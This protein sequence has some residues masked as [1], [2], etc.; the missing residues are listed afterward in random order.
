MSALE[1]DIVIIGSG[2]AGGVLAATLAEHTGQ[3]IVL[4]E[5]GG[6]FTHEFFD[7]RELDMTVLLADR[8]ARATVDGAIPVTG[9]ECVGGGTTVNYALS[10]DPIRDV[11]NGWKHEFGVG[12]FSFDR[13]SNDFGITGLNMATCLADLRRRINVHAPSDA[14][15]N[16][17]NKLF[18]AG[19][20]ASGI[21]T[22]RFEL[23]MIDCIGCGFCGQGCAYDR[24]LSTM[25]TYVRDAQRRNVQLVHHCDVQRIGFAARG[26]DRFATGVQA[27]VRPTTPG[28][29]ANS[30]DRGPLDIRAK[31][32]IVS[33]GAI[34]SPA[35]LQR[36]QI[37]DP[38]QLMGKGLV[39]HPSLPIGGTF[40]RQL[41][42]YRGI[43]GSI[44]SDHFY[45]SHGFYYESL[46]D[47]PMNA[48]IAIP[49]IGADH[50]AIMSQYSKLAGFGVMLVDTPNSANRVDWDAS[51]GRPAIRYRLTQPD[52]AR[53]RYAARVGIEI[54]LAAGA[55]EALLTS[56]EQPGTM[57][58]T[59]FKKRQDAAQCEKLEFLPYQTLIT[60]AHCQAT[61]KMGEDPKRSVVNSRGETHGVR[62]LVVCDSSVFPTSC[63]A[64]P[65][66]SVM[67][68]ARYQA[69]RIAN[70]LSRYGLS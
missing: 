57:A 36:S 33:A 56:E 66:I 59:I 42:N 51:S 46:F 8:G 60:S 13:G 47:H 50:F 6:H 44:Y 18:A 49:G 27:V 52:K 35:L 10:F 37:P 20:K 23:N 32:V 64:N 9:G 7:Q 61:L 21:P 55:N 14:E 16:D 30:V 63:G 40:D 3:R 26:N 39:L 38:Q 24:K 34:A 15:I 53:L 68:L 12:P 70:E 4:L 29:E 48:A 2:A 19:C 54:M 43:T 69:T 41:V 17:N 67:T 65:M 45:G 25:V 5:K 22:K 28:S 11:W 31:L 1:T 62:N 58:A